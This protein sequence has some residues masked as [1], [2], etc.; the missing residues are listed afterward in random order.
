MRALV[1]ADGDPPT[2]TALDDAWPGWDTDVAFVVAADGG[3]RLADALGLPIDQWVGDGDSLGTEG[4]QSLRARGVAVAVAPR[5]KDQSD[6]ELGLQAV[7][8]A[9]ATTIIVLGALGGL[10]P[11]HAL[12]N[13]AMLGHPD[14]IG[15]AVEILDP[16][17]RIRL[18]AARAGLDGAR[19]ERL[20]LSGRVGDLVSLIPLEEVQGASTR[21][22]RFP[23]D[24][25]T[26]PSGR[27]RTLSNVRV[28][29]TAEVSLRV[30]RLLVIE[31]P[32]RFT[33]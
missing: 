13:V 9:G 30:G 23:L 15:R 12:A 8:R 11:D 22:L 5:D 17:A 27:S 1:L 25:A 4:L 32:A 16:R 2:R 20:D 31:A 7:V 19:V 26:L 3:A 24:Q 29:A 33:E 14:C 18:L 21:G 6:S 28:S 10:R